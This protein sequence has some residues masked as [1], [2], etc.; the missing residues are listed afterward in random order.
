M[1]KLK[2]GVIRANQLAIEEAAL[3]LFVRQGYFGTSVRD[4]AKRAG[5]SL[6]NIYNYYP[7]KESIYVSLVK[8]YSER[9]LQLQGGVKPLLGKFDPENLKVL[10]SAVRGIVY[11]HP[12]YWRLMYIDVTEFG[13]RHFAHSFRRL[14]RNL[15]SL[16]GGYDNAEVRAGIDP[17][18]AYASIYLQFFT[19]FLIEKLFGGKQHL[20]RAEDDAI[21][22]IIQIFTQG[23]AVP[24]KGK[25]ARAAGGT[26][27]H[28][29]G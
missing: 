16:A 20:G 28:D 26:D 10:A 4:I 3:K 2:D 21:D 7:N 6:G 25:K 22:Q 5:V 13:N 9:M 11:S 18:L 14:S 24:V 17:A 1:P 8:R 12:D 15:Q 29:E 27:S 23:A 19:Y